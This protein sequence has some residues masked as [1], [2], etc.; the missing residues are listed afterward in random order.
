MLLFSVFYVGSGVS[1]SGL[2]AHTET[3]YGPSHF[4][5]LVFIS[6]HFFQLLLLS[7]RCPFPLGLEVNLYYQADFRGEA[8]QVPL[9][10]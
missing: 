5:R 3:P 7:R 6:I 4:P 9:C 1:N 2:L 10:L 8:L